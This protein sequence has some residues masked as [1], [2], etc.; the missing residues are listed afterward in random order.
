VTDTGIGIRADDIAR[1]FAPFKRID[2]GYAQKQSGTGLGMPLSQRL[3]ELSGGTLTVQSKPGV[4][5]TFTLMLPVASVSER[6]EQQSSAISRLTVQGRGEIVLII[7]PESE[8]RDVLERYFRHAGFLALSVS[9][10][11]EI[12]HVLKGPRLHLAVIDGAIIDSAEYEIIDPLRS[13]G[14]LGDL[15]IVV[16]TG[17]A[18][19]SDIEHFTLAGADLCVTKPVSLRE[20]GRSVRELLD[21]YS[22]SASEQN[23]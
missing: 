1:V 11:D 17:H 3:A 23:R 2:N 22:R 12:E 19:Q 5:S 13:H 20:L 21:N 7:F 16:I 9:S 6:R 15:P 18:F 14:A 4:G 8:E 10:G